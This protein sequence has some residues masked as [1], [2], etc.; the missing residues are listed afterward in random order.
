M[1]SITQKVIS[2]HSVMSLPSEST[3]AFNRSLLK[4]YF[5][6]LKKERIFGV[7]YR[8]EIS[9]LPTFSK[10]TKYAYP[11]FVSSLSNSYTYIVI[12]GAQKDGLVY[13]QLWRGYV[14]DNIDSLEFTNDSH[15]KDVLHNLKIDLRLN[16]SRGNERV[17]EILKKNEL[18]IIETRNE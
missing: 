1:V 15:R 16:G 17:R 7:V 10:I 2:N 9:S 12:G 18:K 14:L 13:S 3:I 11:L 5:K 6:F 4:L 8:N